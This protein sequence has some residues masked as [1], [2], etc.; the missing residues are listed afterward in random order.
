[1]SYSF[2]LRECPR[3]TGTIDK[4]VECGTLFDQPALVSHNPVTKTHT[5]TD[6][7][8]DRDQETLPFRAI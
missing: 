2:I 6:P 3:N 4:L 7:G 1:M 8:E 5:T